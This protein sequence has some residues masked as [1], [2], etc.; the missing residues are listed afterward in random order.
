MVD[1]SQLESLRVQPT[2]TNGFSYPIGQLL[3]SGEIKAI[4]SGR[5]RWSDGPEDGGGVFRSSEAAVAETTI[6]EKV[7]AVRARKPVS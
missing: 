1:S 3:D 4:P 2:N 7:K 5:T 6:A